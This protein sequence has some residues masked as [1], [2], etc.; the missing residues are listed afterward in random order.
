VNNND[1]RDYEEEQ[2]NRR[3]MEEEADYDSHIETP[4]RDCEKAVATAHVEQEVKHW[5]V[6][7]GYDHRD[8]VTNVRLQHRYCIVEDTYEGAR[9]QIMARF[10]TGWA[11]IYP[12][13]DDLEI[14]QRT[15]NGQELPPYKW[16]GAGVQEHGLTYFDHRMEQPS[17]AEHIEARQSTAPR[18]NRDDRLEI[19]REKA[20][21]Y[22]PDE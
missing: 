22:D 8:P 6:T 2:A 15:V 11:V 9:D 5:Y 14:A 10:G 21:Y 3:L 20:G 4:H 17:I 7:F 1:E 18:L 16:R 13:A 19:D 12:N